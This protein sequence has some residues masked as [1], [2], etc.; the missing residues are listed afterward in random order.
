V[1]EASVGRAERNA[2][3]AIVFA[4]VVR[5]RGEESVSKTGSPALP[6]LS[7]ALTE[8][9][10]SPQELDAPPFVLT[11]VGEA[12]VESPARRGR[13]RLLEGALGEHR[14]RAQHRCCAGSSEPFEAKGD[15]LA[16]PSPI[17]VAARVVKARW[18]GQL[19]ARAER[20]WRQ[21]PEAG[22]QPDPRDVSAG[23]TAN[24]RRQATTLPP[25]PRHHSA[26]VRLTPG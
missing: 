17:V 3:N 22:A 18:P 5:A 6:G 23:N 2:A 26:Q 10:Q 8:A 1:I 20:A 7:L 21:W 25:P 11:S 16:N 24:P 13:V 15:G 9:R 4:H 12:W 14:G 19:Q